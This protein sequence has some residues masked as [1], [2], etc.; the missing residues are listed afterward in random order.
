[1][2][3]NRKFNLIFASVYHGMFLIA[4][5]VMLVLYFLQGQLASGEE[6]LMQKDAL[7]C[8]ALGLTLLGLP[9]FFVYLFDTVF[10]QPIL[11][12]IVGLVFFG[13]ISWSLWP[14]LDRYTDAF[15]EMQRVMIVACFATALLMLMF[16]NNG[17]LERLYNL[18]MIF[19]YLLPGIVFLIVWLTNKYITG[20]HLSYVLAGMLSFTAMHFWLN[21]NNMFLCRYISMV[22]AIACAAILIIFHQ[23]MAGAS[24]PWTDVLIYY[25]LVA[26]ALSLG[27]LFALGSNY[28]AYTASSY[29]LM[30][31]GPFLMK[32]IADCWWKGLLILAGIIGGLFVLN[33]IITMFTGKKS[34]SGGRAGGGSNSGATIGA[35]DAE[36]II[37]QELER[38]LASQCRAV[39]V[40]CSITGMTSST[41]S[42]NI[43][44]YG[45]SSGYYSASS[46][47][48]A[49]VSIAR[50]LKV[51][52][53]DKVEVSVSFE[54]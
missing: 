30:I 37:Q 23:P 44:V 22:V 28:Y 27:L 48:S 7:L 17:Y 33:V 12:I 11:E 42:Y 51:G 49:A 34:S 14:L 39:D 45:F 2:F 6:V 5:A 53:C 18:S 9:T 19:K 20:Y 26:A 1:M 31:G 40:D 41:A 54:D 16:H 21:G 29:I 24:S 43:T 13:I 32:L 8:L 52:I 46:V 35:Y 4:G 36:C 15:T 47:R 25:P 10:R 3:L 50:G 38:K